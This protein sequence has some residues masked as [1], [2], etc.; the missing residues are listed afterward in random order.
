[1]E[2]ILFNF[3]NE[4]DLQTVLKQGRFHY[5]YFMFVLVRWEPVVDEEYPSMI[6]F[7]IETIGIPL[8]LGTAGNLNTIG[9][10]LGLVLDVDATNRKIHVDIDTRK[11]LRFSRKIKSKDWEISIQFKYDLLFK[12]CTYC[13]FLTHEFGHCEKKLSDVRAEVQKNRAL[14]STDGVQGRKIQPSSSNGTVGSAAVTV[15]RNQTDGRV[16]PGSSQEQREYTRHD[17][18]VRVTD[19]VMRQPLSRGDKSNK[20][21]RYNPYNRGQDRQQQLREGKS[22]VRLQHDHTSAPTWRKKQEALKITEHKS[23]SSATVSEE[24][25]PNLAKKSSLSNIDAGI[26]KALARPDVPRDSNVTFRSGNGQLNNAP[27]DAIAIEALKEDVLLGGNGSED[28]DESMPDANGNEL[29]VMEEDDLLGEELKNLHPMV[30]DNGEPKQGVEND[31]ETVTTMVVYESQDDNKNVPESP[32][33]QRSVTR[34]LFPTGDARNNQEPIRRASPRL[35]GNV[36]AADVPPRRVIKKSQKAGSK[37]LRK[38]LVDSK[39]PPNPY[40]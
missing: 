6:P 9:H 24:P 21:H 33:K 15:L 25:D 1:M 7:W 38:G 13:G 10:K 11:P 17:T 23:S 29:M 28:L 12:H 19:R 20:P 37:Q 5:N 22:Q 32:S 34:V 8:H 26:G 3:T 27:A 39:N 36:V 40:I 31:A 4:D 30:V 2:G 16:R 14:S 18:H 35:R